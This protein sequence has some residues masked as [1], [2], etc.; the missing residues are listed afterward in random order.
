[1]LRLKVTGSLIEKRLK[2]LYF[3]F[4][5]ARYSS[6]ALHDWQNHAPVS[7]LSCEICKSIRT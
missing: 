5:I 6:N 2:K 4:D 1:M 3:V 7:Q